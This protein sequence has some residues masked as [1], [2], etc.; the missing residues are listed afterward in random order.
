MIPFKLPPWRKAVIKKSTRR[1]SK[2]IH[3]TVYDMERVMH[4]VVEKIINTGFIT[5][6]YFQPSL[7]EINV[8]SDRF[9]LSVIQEAF[10]SSE[11]EKKAQKGKKKL[12][13]G[14]K[15]IPKDLND[16]AQVFQDKKYFKAIMNRSRRMSE[17]LKKAYLQ[18]LKKKFKKLIPMITSGKITVADAK[19][20]MREVWQASKSRVE[21]IFQTETTNY[22][23]K[24]QVEFFIDE[25]EILGFLFDS[26]GD[27]STTDIC[28]SRHG[29]IFRPDHTGKN[30]IAHNMPSCHF[31]CRSHY[32]PLANTPENRKLLEDTKRDPAKNVL[33]P[34]PKDWR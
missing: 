11:D 10:Y 23:A 15:G 5:G 19:K 9:Y 3:S 27:S 6:R 21:T 20:E 17:K 34:L 29:M 8:I 32:I 22:F 16:L 14:L 33:V 31:R 24:V 2:V 12:A 26:A 30:S 4:K 13:G 28:R 1:K 18:K 7:N 25:P